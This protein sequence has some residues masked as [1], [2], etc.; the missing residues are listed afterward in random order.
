MPRTTGAKDQQ[1]RK[2][3][4]EADLQRVQRDNMRELQELAMNGI[5]KLA[6]IGFEVGPFEP[7]VQYVDGKPVRVPQL[8]TG[9][10]IQALS[11]VVRKGL[12]D[13]LDIEAKVASVNIAM[14]PVQSREEFHELEAQLADDEDDDQD[15]EADA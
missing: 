7:Q 1:P 8:T 3:R 4:R 14:V 11:V 13:R 15:D 9:Q 10:I 12:P 5:R 6:Q 2:S